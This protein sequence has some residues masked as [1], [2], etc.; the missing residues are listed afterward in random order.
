MNRLPMHVACRQLPGVFLTSSQATCVNDVC[1]A[2]GMVSLS[3]SPAV[4]NTTPH[5][6]PVADMDLSTIWTMGI[7]C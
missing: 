7:I 5:L 2:T 4:G 1:L 6:L 3:D